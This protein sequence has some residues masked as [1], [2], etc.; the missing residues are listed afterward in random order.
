LNPVTLP[1]SSQSFSP[2]AIPRES[3][4]LKYKGFA[5]INSIQ[6]EFVRQPPKTSS[7]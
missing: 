4:H 2:N 6:A 3:H 1:L 7:L 5:V